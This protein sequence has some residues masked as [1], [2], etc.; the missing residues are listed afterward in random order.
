MP[1][2]SNPYTTLHSAAKYVRLFRRKVFVI[3]L[4]GE[5]LADKAALQSVAEQ[6]ALLWSFSIRLVIVHG[7]GAGLD[8]AC[9]AFGIPVRKVAGRRITSPE[10]LDAAKMVF[11][12]KAHMDLLAG[13]QGAG[14]PIVGLSGV[15]GGTI[16][17]VKRPPV[18]VVDDGGERLLVDFG[19]VGDIQAVDPALINH[20]LAADY[21]P[22]IAPLSG[23]GEGEVFNTNADTIAS[24]V[25]VALQAEKLF[26]L[27]DVPGLLADRE[28]PSSLVPL[29]DL[30]SLAALEAKGAIKGGM[31]PK[32]EAAKAALQGGVASVHLVSGVAKDALLTEVFTNEGSG[33]MLISA[34]D[35]KAPN[36]VAS[37]AAGISQ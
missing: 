37:A 19:L 10:V 20:L 6:L 21:V 26:F 23:G 12:G 18:S 1:L 3:K 8:E 2:S 4:G 34:Q 32:V 22:V 33:T 16:Q 29:A 14:L 15:D 28:Q 30:A 9:A 31:R 27:L 11:A 17:A 7:G 25:A 24:A 35:P 36:G 5:L 13:L